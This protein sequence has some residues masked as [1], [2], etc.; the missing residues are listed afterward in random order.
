MRASKTYNSLPHGS[1]TL[2]F[3][4]CFDENLYLFYREGPAPFFTFDDIHLLTVCAKTFRIMKNEKLS[5]KN[6]TLKSGTKIR[7]FVMM[8]FE[9]IFFCKE[10][11]KLIIRTSSNRFGG[12][13]PFVK[14]II[15]EQFLIFDLKNDWFYFS[16]DFLPELS[17]SNENH[18]LKFTPSVRSSG[19]LYGIRFS[20]EFWNQRPTEVRSFQLRNDKLVENCG[21]KLKFSEDSTRESEIMSACFV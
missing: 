15:K 5:T 10:Q 11:A 21:V 9:K 12:Y 3:S 16:E 18:K 13:N 6:I 7:D 1:K 19:L 14:A 8:N 4:H 20:D 17:T 2:F